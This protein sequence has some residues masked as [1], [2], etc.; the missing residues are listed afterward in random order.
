MHE[1]LDIEVPEQLVDYLH[2]SGR[3]EPGERPRIR[4]LAGGVSNRTV[5]VE[6]A[7]GEAWVMKQ[8]LAKLR[9]KADWFCDPQ[10]IEREAAG[11]RWLAELAPPGAITPLVFEDPAHHL[12]AMQAVPQPHENW[13]STLLAGRIDA[14]A[15]RQ[16]AELAAA[17]H[18]RSADRSAEFQPR[19]ADRQ[20]FEDLR[21]EPYYSYTATQTP[22]AAGFLRALIADTRRRML[23]IVHGDYS[24]KNCLIHAGR[25]VLL[26]H[27]VIHWGDPS[28][29]VGFAMTHLLSKAH[30]LSAHRRRFA[31]A[32]TQFWQTYR[33]GLGDGGVAEAIEPMSV[34]QT[35]GCLLARVDGRSPLEYLT[36]AER[37]AQRS[38]V[39][40]L[41]TATPAT[42]PAL[43]EQFVAAVGRE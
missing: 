9:V 34:R 16:F 26:D 17:I 25:L 41:M 22:A 38:A 6:R 33:H 18:R 42:M 27:E 8:A 32:A 35:L 1:P 29:D 20:F 3:I 10:R 30:H 15:V 4:V 12:L 31:A 2:T 36:P 13:K 37:D 19:F 5:L 28:F 11:L 7:T 24:P 21:I 39:L 14:D 43:I 40:A 23:C